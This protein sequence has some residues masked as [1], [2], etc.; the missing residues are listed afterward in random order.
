M[1]KKL[2]NH[3]N[4]VRYWEEAFV[5]VQVRFCLQDLGGRQANL[6]SR[7]KVERIRFEDG[8][9]LKHYPVKL[10]ANEKKYLEKMETFTEEEVGIGKADLMVYMAHDKDADGKEIKGVLGRSVLETVCNPDK[11]ISRQAH[12]INEWL[13]FPMQFGSVSI[14]QHLSF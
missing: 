11:K 6:G 8:S 4:V 9:E 10:L 13:E 2:G 14:G 3:E 1:L 5:H 12:S 7:I